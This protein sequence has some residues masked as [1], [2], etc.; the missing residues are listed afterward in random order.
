[1]TCSLFYSRYSDLQ[2]IIQMKAKRRLTGSIK[3]LGELYKRGLIPDKVIVEQCIVPLIS[4]VKKTRREDVAEALCVLIGTIGPK[5]EAV[6]VS[7][8]RPL[9]KLHVTN[10]C[11]EE[12]KRG[13]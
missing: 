8:S 1:M 10:L 12:G 13:K 2:V 9:L 5:A 3:F 4:A 11:T 7:F 6:S